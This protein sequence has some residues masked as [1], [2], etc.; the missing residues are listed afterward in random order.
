MGASKS[1]T[2]DF[3]GALYQ[4]LMPIVELTPDRPRRMEDRSH[5]DQFKPDILAALESTETEPRSDTSGVQTRCKAV[6][7]VRPPLPVV[8]QPAE[9]QPA[10]ERQRKTQKKT[11]APKPSASRSKRTLATADRDGQSEGSEVKKRNIEGKTTH[12]R[13][14]KMRCAC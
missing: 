14:L 11:V 8:L 3:L 6:H 13:Q 12:F 1:Q 5:L 4:F 9:L 2:P 7:V 10:A